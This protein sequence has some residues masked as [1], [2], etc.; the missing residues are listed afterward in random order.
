M[1]RCLVS[2]LTILFLLCSLPS[3]AKNA[4]AISASSYCVIDAVTGRILYERDAHKKRGMASTTKIMTA[5]VALENADVDSVAT[6]SYN[7][8]RTEGS[9]LYLKA[10]EKMN[11]QQRRT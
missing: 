10:G 9:S 2:L 1:R 11:E 8:S 3:A 7:A 5:I 4:Q 6:V